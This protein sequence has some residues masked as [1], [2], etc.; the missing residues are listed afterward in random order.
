MSE[1][2]RDVFIKGKSIYL[3]ALKE[4]DINGN[5]YF[6]LNDQEVVKYNSHGRFPETPEKLKEYVRS[7]DAS[8]DK[9]VLAIIDV[10][11]G[12][13][14]GNISLQ[15]IQWVDSNAEIAFLLG[16]TGFQ[17]KGVMKEA[18][19]LLLNHGFNTL[20]LHRIYCGTSS[21]NIPMQK[22]AIKLGMQQEGIRKEAIF[23][24]GRY[25]DMYEYGILRKNYL[26]SQI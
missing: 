23:K 7:I 22:L 14:I 3:R 4:T 19:H 6:W 21:E 1:L 16:E 18:G 17:G 20:N 13:H 26:V 5:Y 9:L 2:N 12:K 8:T 11:S 15:R 25:F 10:S 24:N